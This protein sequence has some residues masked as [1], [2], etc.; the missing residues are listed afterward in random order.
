MLDIVKHEDYVTVSY[1]SDVLHL[2]VW[3]SLC[4]LITDTTRLHLF[5]EEL[6]DSF[7]RELDQH[8]HRCTGSSGLLNH[9]KIKYKIHKIQSDDPFS[10]GNFTV[11]VKAMV[12]KNYWVD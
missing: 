7:M 11:T 8:I 9:I 2:D 1:T 10:F 5:L 6:K 4:D 12:P 3:D